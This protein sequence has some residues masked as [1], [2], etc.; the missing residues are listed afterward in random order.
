MTDNLGINLG[1]VF[2]IGFNI[3]F[4]TYFQN[5]KFKSDYG[6]TYLKP[7]SQIYLHKIQQSIAKDYIDQS[8][9]NIIGDWVKLFIQKGWTSG[10]SFVR[11]YREATDWRI[12]SKIEILYFQCDFHNE[13]AFGTLDRDDNI[14][15]K[16]ILDSQGFENVDINRYKN[17]GEFLKADTLLLTRYFDKY[18]ILVVDLSTFTTSAIRSVTDLHNIQTLKD[19]LHTELNYVRSKSKFC[20]L[21]IDTGDSGDK[22]NKLNE[23][24]SKDLAQYFSAF[25][26]KDKEPVK[27][28]QACSYAWSFYE[29]LLSSGKITPDKP[30]KFNCFGYSDRMINGIALTKEI[31]DGQDNLGILKTCHHIYKEKTFKNIEEARSNVLHVIK[32][33]A[34]K[35]FKDGT[36]FVKD[37]VE[38]QRDTINH[39]KHT[40][41][42]EAR[43]DFFNTA[44]YI[45]ESLRRSLKLGQE[46]ITLRNAH[47]DLICRALAEPNRPLL[48]FTGNPGIGKTTAVAEQ[49]VRQV[50]QGSLLIYVSPRI[51]VNLDI[52]DKFT[53]ETGTQLRSDDLICINT[54][55]AVLNTVNGGY[56]VEYYSN[57]LQGDFKKGQ[58]QFLDARNIRENSFDLPS[59]LVRAADN[60]VQVEN[61]KQA[62]VL[63]SLSEAIHTCIINQDLPNNI[64]A[65]VSIQSLKETRYGNTLQ[66]LSKI[67]SSAYNSSGK[68][69]GVIPKKM[70]EIAN[71]MKN[72]FIMIDEITGSQEGVAFLHGIIEFV[73]EYDLLNPEYGFNVKVITADASLTIQDVVNSH[74]SDSQVQGDKIFVRQVSDSRSEC[75]SVDEFNFLGN[76]A[77]LINANSYPASNLTIDYHIFIQSVSSE[78]D[79]ERDFALD[80]QV[81]N[82]IKEDIFRLLSIDDGQI[83]VYIQ[84]KDSLAKL[85]GYIAQERPS[86]KLNEEYL[87]IHAS[88]SDGDK[89]EIQKYQNKVKVVFMTASASRG[90]SFPNTKHILVEIPGF[91]IEQN[92]MEV[93]QVIYRGRGG[94]L[95]KGAK[96]LT[97]YLSDKAVYYSKTV[98]DD[99]KPLSVNESAKLAKLSLEEACLNVLNILIILK[100]SIM[101]R[102]TGSG[103]IGRD[104]YVI[105]PIGGKALSQAGETFIGSMATLLKEIRKEYKKHPEDTVLRDVDKTLSEL[106]SAQKTE[107][108]RQ[109]QN[110]LPSNQEV[111]YFSIGFK[112]LS[113]MDN[114]LDKI[115]YFPPVEKTYVRGS[116]LIVPLSEKLVKETNYIDLDKIID[117]EQ[118]DKFIGKLMFLVNSRKYPK[119]ITSAVYSLMEL[120][121]KVYSELERS[122]KISQ[123][124]VCSDRYYALPIQAFIA[125]KA[126]REYFEA[127]KEEENRLPAKKSRGSNLSFRDIL[128]GYVYTLSSGHNILPIDSNYQNVPYVIFNSGAMDKLGKSLFNEN[129][130]FQSKEMNILNLIL[131]Q[132]D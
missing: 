127:R 89:A 93:I 101:T 54:N 30:V 27:V 41:V 98:D 130:L 100:A 117:R 37:I 20:G 72:I 5:S 48:F 36:K 43:K 102:I 87:Q 18:Q 57:K 91:Q 123:T 95:D 28:I 24:Y 62:G 49:F 2:E 1:R 63:G 76:P 26:T 131:S 118:N 73:E 121:K 15:Y 16:E 122:Q 113:Q 55:S 68:P 75:L 8:Y 78:Q 71:R 9:K 52:V 115:L 60:L 64:V 59:R 32:S 14:C 84:N 53:E 77:T 44:D 40:E 107:I 67:F 35:S 114:S 17:T 116:L 22:D 66:H 39:I 11:E 34:A 109:P 80:E 6:D 112:V 126:F 3:G 45:P 10:L 125:I 106:L 12:D 79:I 132:E 21:S 99:G 94:D 88:L 96:N 110:S 128:A 119:Q 97:F 51:Q 23:I 31:N 108:S 82:K 104:R 124:S 46:E 56:A 25:K 38:A 19:L 83:I 81:S 42:F 111:S 61:R 85:I 105:I 92:L 50:E 90:L 65:T 70:K 13:N 103:F 58:V 74:L 47:A 4:L 86:F 33:N 69:P 129:Q 7:L 120:V 29:F